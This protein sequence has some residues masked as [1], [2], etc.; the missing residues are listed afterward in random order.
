MYRCLSS[1]HILYRQLQLLL[2]IRNKIHTDIYI[3]PRNSCSDQR[4]FLHFGILIDPQGNAGVDH[5]LIQ[6][7]KIAHHTFPG[8][9]PRRNAGTLC[10][11]IS[12]TKNTSAG[13]Q[14][15]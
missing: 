5:L 15:A 1:K 3:L 2:V 11:Q 14:L 7:Q 4:Q 10:K 8:K 9:L 13:T 6:K 12:T